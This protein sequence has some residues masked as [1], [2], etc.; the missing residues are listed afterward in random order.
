MIFLHT[1][2][3]HAIKDYA[4][5]YTHIKNY[6]SKKHFKYTKPLIPDCLI[7]KITTYFFI[8]GNVQLYA[9]DY[10]VADGRK[11]AS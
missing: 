2:K 5:T 8:I 10:Y 3:N 11:R 4:G 1:Y 6:S 9:G 7:F